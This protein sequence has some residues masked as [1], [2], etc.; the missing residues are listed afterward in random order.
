MCGDHVPNVNGMPSTSEV[1][2][3]DPMAL[4]RSSSPSSCEDECGID[5]KFSGPSRPPPEPRVLSQEQER[6]WAEID[7]KREAQRLQRKTQL[8]ENGGKSETSSAGLTPELR[9]GRPPRILT[10]TSSTEKELDRQSW[11][12]QSQDVQ[13]TPQTSKS[14]VELWNTANETLIIFDWDDTLCP[15]TYIWD[16][17]LLKWSEVAPCFAE[18]DASESSQAASN[19]SDPTLLQVL[20]EQ[21]NAAIAL[22][23]LAVTLGQVVIVTLAKVGWVEMSIRNFMPKLVGLLDELCIEVVYARQA[24]PS[25]YL[26]RAREE[27]NELQKVLKTR[28][29][30][31][32][33]KKFYSKGGTCDGRSWKNVIS[34]GDSAAER[35]ALQ[36]V[37]FRREQKDSRGVPKECR[38]KVVKLLMEPTAER[39]TAEIQVLL[40]WLLTI[41]CQD[42]D[43]D[44]DFS[45]IEEAPDSPISPLLL[46]K[47]RNRRNFSGNGNNGGYTPPS[48]RRLNAT[49]EHQVSDDEA[50][51]SQCDNSPEMEMGRQLTVSDKLI[52]G[53][54]LFPSAL[55]SN[56]Q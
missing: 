56:G 12:S 15:T 54:E 48:G 30:S 51:A 20:D 2:L 3:E 44:I 8:Q 40:M 34:I 46:N 4:P 38:C 52:D 14:H 13:L 26:R 32:I 29:M 23:N 27:D 19:E 18:N 6:I 25:R 33:V 31:Q 11:A 42:D 7:E 5:F 35:L 21:Q 10:P 9:P 41:V 50:D 36:D 17:P 28:A 16:H 39:L 45:D 53:K 1:V 49:A 55:L 22:L 43:L 24:I 47:P 37:I